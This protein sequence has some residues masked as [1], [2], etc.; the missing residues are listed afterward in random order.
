MIVG[1][2]FDGT[3]VTHD[4]PEVGKD[5]GAA[6][7]LKELTDAGHQ[8]ILFTVRCNH[9][10]PPSTKQPDILAIKGE[11][12]NKAVNWF[13][14]NNI[15]LYGINENPEQHSWTSSP[16]PYW[17]LLIDDTA[18]GAPLIYNCEIHKKPFIDWWRMREI[19]VEKGFLK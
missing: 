10:F 14:E 5:I 11:Y 4:F 8:L 19:L 12:L 13:K 2:D 3:C 18:A 6:S 16:K 1:V 15:P 17:H 9:D 7:V